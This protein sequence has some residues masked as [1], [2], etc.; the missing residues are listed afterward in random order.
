[1]H[2]YSIFSLKKIKCE[3]IKSI[4]TKSVVFV[5]TSELLKSTSENEQTEN[6]VNRTV[7]KTECEIV[8]I[9]CEAFK[10]VK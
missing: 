7:N 4:F 6:E 3:H 2:I 1:M 8:R 9:L 10:K 5:D